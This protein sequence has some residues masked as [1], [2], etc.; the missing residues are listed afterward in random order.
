[1]AALTD[2]LTFLVLAFEGPDPVSQVGGLATRVNTLTPVLA[3]QGHD[4]HQYFMG[5]AARPA[6]EIHNQVH[7]HRWG[8]DLMR[9]YP[10]SCYDGEDLKAEDLA[11]SWPAHVLDTWVRPA[12]RRGQR[13]VVLAEDW[14]TVP[15]VLALSDVAW[16]QG[17]RRHLCLVWN[18]NNPF[19]FE[20][21]NWPR[22]AY[23]ANLTTVSRWMK[24]VMWG[25]GVN[26][27]VIPNGLSEDAFQAPP[28]DDAARVRS[29]W[30]H[31]VLL[32]KIG[33]YDPNKC[34]L[35]AIGA[36][37][38]LKSRGL[39]TQLLVRGNSEPYGNEVR[40]LARHLDLTWERRPWPKEWWATLPESSAD[41][42]EITSPIPAADLKLLYRAADAVLANSG[43][44][45]FGLVGLEVMGAGGVAVV[46][47]TGE[48]YARPFVNAIT[49]ESDQS[50]EL[51]H[52]VS[53]LHHDRDL[54]A[55]IRSGGLA[56]APSYSWHAL[57]PQ[58][59]YHLRFFLN[60]PR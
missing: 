26:P 54:T 57:M 38:L 34:W 23:V 29:A 20:R 50:E 2:T 45:P 30:P 40:T 35:P 1:M 58:I 22:L 44:E 10:R 11:R 12:A 60:G 39:R 3:Q 53:T 56:T 49:V 14:Q 21:I 52:I 36:V 42:V 7:W 4:V 5:D 33:R 48:D 31:A 28:A 43:R 27:V 55:A 13:V 17:L 18:A 37:P 32:F 25:F 41:I 51:A 47:S 9:K 16:H 8:Q 19:G 59:F 24:H 6:F 15:A 46:G